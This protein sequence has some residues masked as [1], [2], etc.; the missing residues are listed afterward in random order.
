MTTQPK[1]RLCLFVKDCAHDMAKAGIGDARPFLVTFTL[2][3]T[4]Y[5][6]MDGNEH[7]EARADHSISAFDGRT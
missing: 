5:M 4:P 2:G 6:A 1:T 3:G 7:F